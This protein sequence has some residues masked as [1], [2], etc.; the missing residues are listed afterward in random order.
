[1]EGAVERLKLLPKGVQPLSNDPMRICALGKPS[2]TLFTE[3]R[4]SI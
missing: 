2:E 4:F 1:M 3:A